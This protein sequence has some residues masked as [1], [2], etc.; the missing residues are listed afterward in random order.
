MNAIFGSLSG[1][2]FW[3]ET[4]NYE[5]FNINRQ[6]AFLGRYIDNLSK[7]EEENYKKYRWTKNKMKLLNKVYRD[8]ISQLTRYNEE[9]NAEHNREV[10][11]ETIKHLNKVLNKESIDRTPKK[12]VNPLS[13]PIFD[14]KIPYN[15]I[16]Y[17][18]NKQYYNYTK[19]YDKRYNK[20]K[21]AKLFIEKSYKIRNQFHPKFL[22]HLPMKA[23]IFINNKIREMIIR[24]EKGI[25]KG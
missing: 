16:R 24:L 15:P 25:R 18:G 9:I 14:S 5:D 20:Y 13:E 2:R 11:I 10:L 22:D 19:E 1:N 3:E 7:E 6:V 21:G 17:E 23:Q 12:Y 8:F 4:I